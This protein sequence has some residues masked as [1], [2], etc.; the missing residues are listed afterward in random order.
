MNGKK[1]F[2]LMEMLAAITVFVILALMVSQLVGGASIAIIASR[3]S[4]DADSQARFVFGRMAIDIN[5]M[6]KRGDVDMIFAKSPQGAGDKNDKMFFYSEVAAA[7][8]SSLFGGNSGDPKNPVSLV[9]YRIEPDVRNDS[10]LQLERLG[11]GLAWD[12]SIL[13]VNNGGGGVVFLTYEP[14]G[15]IPESTLDGHW[16][17]AIG[18]PP[19][20]QGDNSRAETDYHVIGDQ[21]FRFEYCFLL[22]DGTYANYPVKNYNGLNAIARAGAP[23]SG[24]NEP[25]GTRWFDTNAGRAYVCQ[26]RTVDADGNMQPV[27]RSA[28]LQDVSAIVVAI[29]ILDQASR[30]I[31][32]NMAPLPALFD[33]PSDNDLDGGGRPDQALLMEQKWKNL[34]NTPGFARNAGIPVAAA[35]Q[36]KIYQ[37]YFYLNNPQ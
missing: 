28:G 32:T 8:D 34:I 2:S 7:Y 16:N 21:I 12:E 33:D 35:G 15:I 25:V 20:Y 24:D 18:N 6:L 22:N 27:W 4:M 9:G 36:I 37:R 26:S 5:K 13:P 29:A 19:L 31:V 30:K 3:K 14:S 10:I 17:Q 1:G 11:K 23:T